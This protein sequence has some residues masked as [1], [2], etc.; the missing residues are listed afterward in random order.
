MIPEQMD[1]LKSALKHI[2]MQTEWI[3]THDMLWGVVLGWLHARGI[4]EEFYMYQQAKIHD[5]CIDLLSER[6]HSQEE[7]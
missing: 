7:R 4:L 3:S 6:D 1:D 5:Y 2:V